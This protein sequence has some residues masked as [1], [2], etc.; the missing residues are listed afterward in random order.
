MKDE[1]PDGVPGDG[2][3]SL[4]PN[5]VVEPTREDF[6]AVATALARAEHA[7]VEA[8]FVLG[9]FPP[10]SLEWVAQQAWQRAANRTYPPVGGYFTAA[11]APRSAISEKMDKF[12]EALLGEA[13]DEEIM[14]LANEVRARIREQREADRWKSGE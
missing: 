12:N 3:S 6:E 9:S 1:I 2:L 13:S 4:D 14:G 11:K 8:G 10:P 5:F 7:L